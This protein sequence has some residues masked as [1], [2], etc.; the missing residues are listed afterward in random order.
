MTF[1]LSPLTGLCSLLIYYPT[2]TGWGYN[3]CG[4]DGPDGEIRG[5]IPVY[6]WLGFG[7]LLCNSPPE[8]R[9]DYPACVYRSPATGGQEL[10]YVLGFGGLGFPAFGFETIV[11]PLLGV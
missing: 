2:L 9:C 4:P 5:A 8:F 7:L 3:Y 6:G 11:L 1:P 10:F